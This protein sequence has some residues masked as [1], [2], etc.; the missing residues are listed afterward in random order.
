MARMNAE[1]HLTE[2]W[3]GNPYLVQ[4]DASRLPFPDGTFDVVM[5][6][7]LLEHFDS[8]SMDGLLR[9]VVRTVRKGGI[10]VADIVHSRFSVRTIAR[11]S[12]LIGSLAWHAVTLRWA[13][14]AT[15]P[16]VYLDPFY[17]NGLNAD[18][19]AD[20]LRRTGLR[21][22]R[23]DVCRPFA[24]LALSGWLE[25]SYV[26]LLQLLRPQWEWFDRTQPRWGRRWGWMYLAWGR[27]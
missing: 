7:G 25:R 20:A 22:V 16:A 19:W 4:C 3:A 26:R 24:P 2:K 18:D 10:F 9:E 27:K 23:V 12:N 5:S 8:R 13:R 1:A 21:G 15:V 17:E 14:L 6:Y 11:W